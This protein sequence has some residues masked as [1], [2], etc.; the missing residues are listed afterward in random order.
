MTIKTNKKYLEG[1]IQGQYQERKKIIEALMYLKNLDIWDD[2]EI[3]M[4][5]KQNLEKILI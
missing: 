5:I 1:F 3:V 2:L 4:E